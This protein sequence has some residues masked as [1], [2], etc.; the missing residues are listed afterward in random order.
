MNNSEN[1]KIQ[2]YKT[3]GFRVEWLQEYLV[4]PKYF[5]HRNSLGTAQVDGFKAWLK[6]AEINDPKNNLT[7]FGKFI[8]H[9]Y[10]DEETL[11]WELILTNLSYH[12]FI[13][14][15]FLN[16]ISVGKEFDRK[17]LE[18]LINEQ[19]YSVKGKTVSNA[20]AAFVQTLDYSPLGTDMKLGVP[21]G[22]KTRVRELYEDVSNAGLVYNLYKYAEFKG[23]RS[24][25]VSDFYMDD[26]INGPYKTLGV[27]KKRFQD[28]LRSLNSLDNRVLIAELAM[29]L[30]SITLRD[31]IT[32]LS[33][34]ESL[35]K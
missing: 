1:A 6:D 25:R 20:V 2:G 4:D 7:K 28:V 33:C 12:S 15:W 13:V 9:I 34:I 5:W 22:N 11:T 31:D 32:S 21:T 27:S 19:G 14:K 16:N 17:T 3:F 10:Q 29:G 23:V 26:C 24:L 8:Q 18:T 35:I 30:D